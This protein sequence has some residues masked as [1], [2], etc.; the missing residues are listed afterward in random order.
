MALK[1]CYTRL[2]EDYLGR[3]GLWYLRECPVC[4]QETIASP[5]ISR[6]FQEY[7]KVECTRG[8]FTAQIGADEELLALTYAGQLFRSEMETV[9]IGLQVLQEKLTDQEKEYLLSR[10]KPLE[11]PRRIISIRK[12]CDAQLYYRERKLAFLGQ[13]NRLTEEYSTTTASYRNDGRLPKGTVTSWTNEVYNLM[14]LQGVTSVGQAT[15]L[16]YS[17]VENSGIS[18]I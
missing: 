15:Q 7:I 4:G 13:Q 17:R 12:R 1:R 9:Y 10:L 6:A 16:L 2:G 11:K 3:I 5:L 8:N 14:K 18:M